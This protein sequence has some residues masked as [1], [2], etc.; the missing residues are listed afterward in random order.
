MSAFFYY[1]FYKKLKFEKI[2]SKSVTAGSLY[3]S[4][5]VSNKKNYLKMIDKVSK[6]ITVKYL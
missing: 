4:G 2:L 6:K 5:F 3:A 1:Y